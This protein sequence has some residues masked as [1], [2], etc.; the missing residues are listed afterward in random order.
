M[1]LNFTL[2]FFF[3]LAFYFKCLSQTTTNQSSYKKLLD[4]GDN[5]TVVSQTLNGIDLTIK[6]LV[7][8][9]LMVIGE[10]IGLSLEV[11][12]IGNQ[13]SQ[14][15]FMMV[16]LSKDSLYDFDDYFLTYYYFP[17]IM[18]E[19]LIFKQDNP[20]RNFVTNIPEGDYYLITILDIANMIKETNE[21]NNRAYSKLKLVYPIVTGTRKTSSNTFSYTVGPNPAKD[22][23]YFYG[24][25]ENSIQVFVYSGEGKLVLSEIL[26]SDNSL[27]TSTLQN[28]VYTLQI[29]TSNGIETK[30]ILI[31][32]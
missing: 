8:D 22:K 3:S 21:E 18:P 6:N 7:T 1:K 16:Y 31:Q 2:I 9:T 19:A 17:E 27:N 25:N 5:H 14:G 15:S 20:S 23:I 12:N 13:P 32:N 11:H 26:K 4:L 24:N 29:H 10:K 28:G 30:K